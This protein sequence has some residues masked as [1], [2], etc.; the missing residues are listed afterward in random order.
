M[1]IMWA[2]VTIVDIHGDI[3]VGR[4]DYKNNT[5]NKSEPSASLL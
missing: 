2:K 4:Q 5:H 1:R 3:G